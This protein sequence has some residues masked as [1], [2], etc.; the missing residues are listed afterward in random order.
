MPPGERPSGPANCLAPAPW[1]LAAGPNMA[2]SFNPVM[3]SNWKCR[4]LASCA[5]VSVSPSRVDGSPNHVRFQPKQSECTGGRV[6]VS[7][8]QSRSQKGKYSY[9]HGVRTRNVKSLVD[10]TT[11]VPEFDGDDPELV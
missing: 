10:V 4:G 8:S 9:E 2:K 6:L 7:Y 11:A 3:W 5:I 1:A